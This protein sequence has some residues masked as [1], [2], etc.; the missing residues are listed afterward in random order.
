MRRTDWQSVLRSQLLAA[1]TS[2]QG[3]GSG[4]RRYG[5]PQPVLSP[6][7]KVR[8]TKARNTQNRIL[9]PSQAITAARP[10]PLMAKTIARIANKNMSPNIV[11]LLDSRD[12][13]QSLSRYQ[14][15]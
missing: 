13:G 14:S 12:P 3:G 8:I 15:T 1:R 7:I 6:P 4:P 9:A 11:D 5:Q 10:N 2:N